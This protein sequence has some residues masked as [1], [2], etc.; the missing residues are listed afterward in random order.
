MNGEIG[1]RFNK[2]EKFCGAMTIVAAEKPSMALSNDE[3]GCDQL[4]RFGEEPLED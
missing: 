4:W 2:S 3:S 1:E